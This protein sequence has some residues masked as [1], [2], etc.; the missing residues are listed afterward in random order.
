MCSAITAALA[1]ADNGSCCSAVGQGDLAHLLLDADIVGC[2]RVECTHSS[3]GSSRQ[4]EL[5][6]SCR[7]GK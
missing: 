1:A 2:S 5:L 6:P 7:T 4:V 3:S